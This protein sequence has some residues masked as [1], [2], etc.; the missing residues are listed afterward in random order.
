MKLAII[1][2]IHGNLPALEAVLDDIAN[3]AVDEVYH[4]GDLVG[5]NPF[6]NEVVDKVKG[7]GIPG[8]VGNYDMAAAA[9][10]P[11]P[12]GAYLNPAIS[13]MAKSIYRWTRAQVSPETRDYLLGL[14]ER[15]TLK[16]NGLEI[17][18]AHGSPRHIREYLRP[19]LSDE[20]LRPV[21]EAIP[22]GALFTGHTHL[23]L[24]RQVAGKWLINPG[25]VGFPKD[26]DYRAGWALVTVKGGLKVEIRRVDYDVHRTVDALLAAG[27][28]AQAAHDL[29]HGRRMKKAG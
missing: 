27:L 20:E 2:D 18:L 9:D 24:V 4:L 15:L 19:R 26:G 6:P 12:I 5:Y 1:S 17:L 14:P 8:V 23:P 11:D 25:S 16:L 3:Q 28:P 13:E 21:L 22:A 29:R 10:V 7:L